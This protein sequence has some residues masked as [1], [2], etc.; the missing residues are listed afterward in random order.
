MPNDVLFPR[1]GCG[2]G[3]E[4][5]AESVSPTASDLAAQKGLL[6]DHVAMLRRH[7]H[8]VAITKFGKWHEVESARKVQMARQE[9]KE[10]FNGRLLV[11]LGIG[12]HEIA[13]AKECFIRYL[14]ALGGCDSEGQGGREAPSLSHDDVM[15]CNILQFE[16]KDSVQYKLHMWYT[17]V[18]L[19]MKTSHST[20]NETQIVL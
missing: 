10:K 11:D 6:R 17:T 13:R 18:W 9:V 7:N 3:E 15:L 1:P 14:V 20:T 12:S 2:T 5:E 16:T 4:G 19:S 8:C